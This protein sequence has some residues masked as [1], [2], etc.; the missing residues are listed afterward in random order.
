MQRFHYVR[1]GSVQVDVDF[2]LSQ[3][4]Q[5]SGMSVTEFVWESW[6]EQLY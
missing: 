1:S 5:A 6:E 2:L 3:M 4:G